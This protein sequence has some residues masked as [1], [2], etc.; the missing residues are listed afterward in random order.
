[1]WLPCFGGHTGPPLLMRDNSRMRK[2]F[3]AVLVTVLTASV[4]FAAQDQQIS[5]KLAALEKIQG[6]FSFV[7]L[8]DNRSGDDEYRKL[9]SMAM[10]RK[11]DFIVNTGD[12]VPTQGI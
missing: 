6:K 9:I 12:Q 5:R 11:P 1:M 7:V 3:T 10:E 2:W 8:G 4:A